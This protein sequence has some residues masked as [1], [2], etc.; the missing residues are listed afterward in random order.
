MPAFSHTMVPLDIIEI[1]M[2]L[3]ANA[4]DM[5]SL[6]T[7]SLACHC[8]L[9]VCRKHVFSKIELDSIN[10]GSKAPRVRLFKRLLDGNPSIAGYV[11]SLDYVN[12]FH[13][14]RGPPILRRLHRVHSFTFGFKDSQQRMLNHQQE[15]EK[16]PSFLKSSLSSFIQSNS[17]A[18]LS[19]FNI[20]DV[21]LT[22]FMYFPHLTGLRINNV[23]VANVPL[24]D[25]FLKQK[26]SPK[27]VSLWVRNSSLGAMIKPLNNTTP[28][29]API[30]NLTGLESLSIVIDED[31]TI[32]DVI[33][34]LLKPSE[35]LE[36]LSF[37]GSHPDLNF[38]G[39]FASSLTPGSLKTLKTVKLFPM[40]E[41]QEDNPYLYF[42]Q[43]LEHIAGKNVL[44]TLIVHIDIDT[45]CRCTTDSSQWSQLDLILSEPDGFPLLRRVEIK[46][47]IWHWSR[48]YSEFHTRLEDIGKGSFPWL[49]DNKN[50][51]FGFEVLEED[52]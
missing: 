23:S 28:G 20:K 7:C 12:D 10:Q 39:S 26:G 36:C 2:E 46:V 38:L 32:M 52:V 34:S 50:V 41:T 31:P 48:D 19:L 4:N 5:A 40:L 15:W 11:R 17:I 21:P 45:D 18:E 22:V 43:E 8:F 29:A 44:E 30:L 24:S 14:K 13:S 51:E 33:K 1:I 47:T 35:T 6:K 42:A 27:L 9:A 49:R 25:G 16:M 37:S 3:L